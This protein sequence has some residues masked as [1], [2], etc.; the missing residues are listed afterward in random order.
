MSLDVWFLQV[1]M[2]SG[3]TAVAAIRVARRAENRG[4]LIVVSAVV[5]LFNFF[6]IRVYIF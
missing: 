4:K 5:R 3:A 2:S 1:G 6:I